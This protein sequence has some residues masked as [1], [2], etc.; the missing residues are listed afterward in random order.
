MPFTDQIDDYSNGATGT[1]TEIN[2]D[3]GGYTVTGT[4]PTVNWNSLDNGAQVNGDGTRAFTV[5]F[6]THVLGAAM[7]ISGSDATE[8]YYIEVNGVTVDLNTL[9]ANGDVTMTQSGAATHVINADGSISGGRYTDGSIAE[10]VF[11]IP[12]QSLGAY[13]AGASFGNWDYIE[14]GIDDTTFD[15]VCFTAGTLIETPNGAVPV[16]RLQVGDLVSTATGAPQ[17]LRWI[18]GRR[19]SALH[20]NKH[21]NLRPIRITADALAPGIPSQD[22]CV[23]PQ[24]RMLLRSKT[25]ER[26]F[27]QAEVLVAATRLTSLPGVFQDP[28]GDGVDYFHLLFDDHQVVIAN[29]APSESLFTGPEALKTLPPAARAELAQIMPNVFGATARSAARM[30]PTGRKQNSLVRRIA[31][32]RKHPVEAAPVA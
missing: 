27:G 10:L 6:D 3:T 5:T 29:G 20:L 25:A 12:V 4:S 14:V 1:L 22:L 16:E 24:H 15:I 7:Q 9:I 18:G 13:G 26:M 11:N 19:L 2:G 21:Q 30:I 17:P 28:P 8:F 23:S 31:Q 32:N